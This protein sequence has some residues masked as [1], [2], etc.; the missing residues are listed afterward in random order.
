[1]E[2]RYREAIR[3]KSP[4]QPHADAEE[5]SPLEEYVRLFPKWALDPLSCPDVELLSR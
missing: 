5:G 4:L 1:M 2:G 3:L